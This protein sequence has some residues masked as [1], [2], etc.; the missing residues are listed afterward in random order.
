MR[1]FLFSLLTISSCFFSGC[2]H[3]PFRPIGGKG[4]AAKLIVYPRH[5][6]LTATLD[7]MIVYIKHDAFDAPANGK[8]DD[9]AYCDIKNSQPTCTF[10]NL[11]NGN[12]YLYSRGVDNALPAPGYV[13][14]GLRFAITAQQSISISIPVGE[15]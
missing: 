7:S 14:G 15:E 10:S 2:K 6:G 3:E 4:G 12:Y 5:H 1:Y 11:W 13:R 8:Y 9:S